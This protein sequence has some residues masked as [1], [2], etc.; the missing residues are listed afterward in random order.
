MKNNIYEA[1][2]RERE[3]LYREMAL[4]EINKTES[5]LNQY[6]EMKEC[7]ELVL[8]RLEKEFKKIKDDF[9]KLDKEKN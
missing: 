6:K 5:L 4:E 7:D 1:S 3:E 9:K 2:L 8:S